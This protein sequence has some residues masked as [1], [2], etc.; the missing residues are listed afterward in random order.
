MKG[1]IAA[2]VAV[3]AGVAG[4]IWVGKAKGV[5]PVP[6]EWEAKASAAFKPLVNVVPD[7]VQG[8]RQWQTGELSNEDFRTKVGAATVAFERTQRDV[9]NTLPSPKTKAAGELYEHS[10]ALYVDV[11]R[12]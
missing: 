2:V 5:G 12:I 9:R 10:A 8:A 1:A 6:K 3:V 7:L 11:G 4:M